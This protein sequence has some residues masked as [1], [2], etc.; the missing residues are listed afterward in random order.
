MDMLEQQKNNII[1]QLASIGSA[2]RGQISEQYYK[3]KAADGSE[4]RTGPYYVWQRWVNGRKHSVRVPPEEIEQVQADLA[5]GRKMQA[6]M[7]KLFSAVE[8]NAVRGNADSKKK[9]R[10]NRPSAGAKSR[11]F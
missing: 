4:R 10:Q 8:Q 7:E 3:R 1:E 11:M 6:L 5:Q 9:S 2:R